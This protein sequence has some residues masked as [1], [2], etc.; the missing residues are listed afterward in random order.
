VDDIR[1]VMDAAGSERAAAFGASEVGDMQRQEDFALVEREWHRETDVSRYAPS[2]DA[3][4]RAQIAAFFRR[5]GLAPV[6]F[7]L[8]MFW[9]PPRLVVILTP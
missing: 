5:S 2:V 6:A 3:A 4:L 9:K 7:G 8:L 1:T